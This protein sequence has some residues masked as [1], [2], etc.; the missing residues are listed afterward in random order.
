MTAN[1]LDIQ[2]IL[3]ETIGLL[4]R[5]PSTLLA[6]ALVARSWVDTA[7]S[8]LFRAPAKTK[9]KFPFEESLALLFDQALT[10][11]TRLIH[12]VR[13][14]SFAVGTRST[15]IADEI[16]DKLSR[17]QFARLERLQLVAVILKSWP[18]EAIQRLVKSPSLRYFTVTDYSEASPPP[19]A[20]WFKGSL[21]TIQ[22][23]DLRYRLPDSD[24]PSRAAVD[25][26]PPLFV[27]SARLEFGNSDFSLVYPFSLSR[28]QAL[29]LT[30]IPS[31]PLDIIPMDL[32][33]ILDLDYHDTSPVNLSVFPNLTVLRI[34][35][36]E[37]FP[38]ALLSNLATISPQNNIQTMVIS[39]L[40]LDTY[41]PWHHFQSIDSLLSQV[42]HLGDIV[43]ELEFGVRKHSAPE[44]EKRWEENSRDSFVNACERN[45][46]RFVVRD[47]EE[48]AE[49]WHNLVDKL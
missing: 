34:N 7:Q 26:I 12:H 28:V 47:S 32:I 22:H 42:P 49:W 21:S 25:S 33:R 14:L 43:V 15:V 45:A 11:N 2:E 3:D 8:H 23:L 36:L 24:V 27:K 31:L 46:F 1:P 38:P 41:V 5:E 39:Y 10:N 18:S 16:L 35:V 29:A 4:A 20:R 6:C 9:P 30:R 48:T 13:E 44:Q 17:H 19:L 37:R 40:P